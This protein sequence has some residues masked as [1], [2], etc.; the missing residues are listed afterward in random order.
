MSATQGYRLS[1]VPDG[2][3]RLI[4]TVTLEQESVVIAFVWA[5]LLVYWESPWDVETR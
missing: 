5:W 3:L 4:K 2:D 1:Q